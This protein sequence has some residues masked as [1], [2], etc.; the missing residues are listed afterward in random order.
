LTETVRLFP[1][2]LEPHL[3]ADPPPLVVHV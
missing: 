3:A 1:Q 2:L